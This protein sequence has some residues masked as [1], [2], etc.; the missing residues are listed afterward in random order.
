MPQETLVV[1]PHTHWD[2]EWYRSHEEF[3]VRLVALVDE[4]LALLEGD[5][6]FRHFML[7]GQTIVVDDYLAVRPDARPRIEKLVRDGRLLVGPWHVLP[8]EWLVSAEALIRNLR[9]GLAKAEALGQAMRVGYVPDQFGHVGQLPQIFCRFGFEGAAL[10]RGVGDDVRESAFWWE[11]PDGSRILTLY[12]ATGYGNAA[13]LPLDPALLARRLDRIVTELRGFVPGSTFCLMNGSD[14]LP[15]QPGLPAALRKATARPG[16]DR[17]FEISTLPRMLERLAEE[18]AA[19]A[20][21]HRGELRSGL[22][23][24]LL[25]GCASSRLAQKQRDAANDRWLCR[26]LEPL[27]ALAGRLGARVDG[28]LLSFTWSVA[29]ENH[30][31]DSICGCSVD[32]VHA[33]METRFDRVEALV[34]AQLEGVESAVASALERPARSERAGDAFA[35]W[36]PHASGVARVEAALE[37]DLPGLDPAGVEPG[38]RLLAHVRGANDRQI[39]A[40]VEGVE[41]GAA[42]RSSFSLD[43][44]RAMLAD[45][46]REMMGYHANRV[47]FE[48]TDDRLR[49]VVIAGS[50]PRGDF[51]FAEAKRSLATVLADP[52]LREL[53]IE[54]LRPARVLVSFVDRLAGHG[55]RVYRIGA[56]R[57]RGSP[58]LASGRIAGGAFVESSLWRVD[59]DAMGRVRLERRSDGLVIDD[60]LRVVSEGDRG[61]TYNFDPVASARSL[62]RPARARVRVASA[63][64]AEATLSIAL[65]FRV[66]EG[67]TPDRRGRSDRVV[68]LPVELRLRVAEGVDAIEVSVRGQNRARDHRL[69]LLFRAPFAAERFRVESAFEVVDRPIAPDRTAFGSED[70]AEFPIGACPQ[71]RFATLAGSIAALSVAAR[72]NSEVE[73]LPE[74]DGTSALAVTLLRAVGWL[75]ASDLSLRPAPAGPLFATPGAQAQGTF[76]AELLLFVHPVDDPEVVSRAHRFADPP[77]AF[78]IGDGA[79][80][81]LRDGDRLVEIDDP[82][83]IVSAIE[84]GGSAALRI[85]VYESSGHPRRVHVRVPGANRFEAV[86][87]LGRPETSTRLRFDSDTVEIELR[88]HQIADIE[89]GFAPAPPGDRPGPPPVDLLGQPRP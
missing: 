89:A 66:P 28:E 60:A 61:D 73:A 30:P 18:Q 75:S 11:A 8:D 53:S 74:A 59:A 78:A 6:G 49:V 14:H 26:V 13:N 88:A 16:S 43:L 5:P 33:Q 23:A 21:S 76:H 87:L 24:P 71:R 62:D 68:D 20:P 41:P 31:H 27:A 25:P 46:P 51:D 38:R 79:G 40:H 77:H 57:A 39:P 69:R 29:L 84:P 15:P 36:N 55:L 65:V 82:A 37:L 48:R 52:T 70:P 3:R 85:R 86:D 35:V 44:A 83:V 19:T 12:L 7:D 54:L 34:R 4:V 17:H 58:R 2:R 45:L 22:R 50:V 42:W 64:G 1:V 10:W 63:D 80:G 32:A 56:G 72:G 47:A 81:R 67:L 9:M